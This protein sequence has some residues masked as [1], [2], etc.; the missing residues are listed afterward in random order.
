MAPM[1]HVTESVLHGIA[2]CALHAVPNETG[3]A[4][5]GWREGVS[6]S[7]RDF[8]EIPSGRPE[9]ARYELIVAEL[10]A[11][12]ASYLAQARDTRLGYVGSWH[13]HPAAVGPSFIDKHTFLKTARAH[14]GPLVFLVAATDGLSTVLHSTWAGPR[15]GRHRLIRQEPIRRG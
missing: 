11:A 5:I 10:N 8:I 14:A 1:V 3:G 12:L 2:G 13:S 9:R 4:L 7:V 15:N 6:V